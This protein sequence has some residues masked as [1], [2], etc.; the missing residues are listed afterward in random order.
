MIKHGGHM[1]KIIFTCG[2]I[3]GISIYEIV[4]R[5]GG[6]IIKIELPL[7]A[8]VVIICIALFIAT[9]AAAKPRYR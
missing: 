1:E 8:Y 6:P 5:L 9:F 3:V 2:L 4:D 7:W